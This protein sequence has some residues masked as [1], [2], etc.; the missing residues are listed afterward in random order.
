LT[1]REL[2]LAPAFILTVCAGNGAQCNSLTA[3]DLQRTA[4]FHLAMKE[5]SGYMT[6]QRLEYSHLMNTLLI[7]RHGLS[8]HE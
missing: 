6:R 7:F 2:S 5:A 8:F 1:A 3:N 4:C